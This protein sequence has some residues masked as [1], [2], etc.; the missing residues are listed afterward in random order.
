MNK[1]DLEKL[2]LTDEAVIDQI[3]VLHGKGIEAHK[4]AAEAAKVSADALQAQL[5]EANKAIEGF[6]G[7]DIEG[8]KKASEDYKAAAE[9]ATTEATAQIAAIKFDHAL[10][11]E[12]KDAK[13]KDPA[14][15]IPHLK[16]DMLKLDENGKF[17]GLTEQL[18]PLQ[19]SKAY[20]FDTDT[21]QPKIVTG[22]QSHSVLGD[23]TIIA[24]R[25]AA[26]L[27]AAKK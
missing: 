20:L 24:A 4:T 25:E 5:A 18:K 19:E 10:E 26:G 2:G 7:M 27:P 8:I 14:D 17:I 3:I 23:A 12:L 13:V 6:K 11:K 15:V 9:K 16:R 21:P 1:K 22:A